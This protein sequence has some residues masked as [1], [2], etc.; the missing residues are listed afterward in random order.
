MVEQLMQ[1]KLV[2]VITF[3]ACFAFIAGAFAGPADNVARA[4]VRLSGVDSSGNSVFASGFLVQPYSARSHDYVWLVTAA[5]IFESC[6]ETVTVGF[7]RKNNGVFKEFP[8]TVKIRENGHAIYSRHSEY[9]IAI[10]KIVA[11]A[12]IDSCLLSHDFICDDKMLENSDFGIG[13]SL[14]VIGYPYGEACNDAG[15]AYARTAAVSSFPVLPSSLYPVFHVDFEVF[16]GY[17]G[18]PVI[19]N[20]EK[21]RF[22]LAG[23]VLEEVFLEEIQPTG[24]KKALRTR[25]GLGLAR[26]LN[27]S[28]IKDFLKSVNH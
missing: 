26:A 7:R 4:V 17:S 25:R 20:D 16:A 14:L 2:F 11:N 13:S 21:G 15:F 5:H 22:C 8:V 19:L 28:I 10:L 27:G 6:S 18:A 23:M 12:E 1:K 9:D 3:L 24:K